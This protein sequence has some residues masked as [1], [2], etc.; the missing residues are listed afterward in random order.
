M[1]LSEIKES[2]FPKGYAP[3]NQNELDQFSDEWLMANRVDFSWDNTKNILVLKGSHDDFFCFHEYAFKDS[4]S[5]DWPREPWIA[6]RVEPRINEVG[7]QSIL[8]DYFLNKKK[9]SIDDLD[10][11]VDF[12]M[13]DDII[14]SLKN[15]D[16][17]TLSNLINQMLEEHSQAD[18]EDG[19]LKIPIDKLI[20]SVNIYLDDI[21]FHFY[22]ESEDAPNFV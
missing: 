7:A 2:W 19:I 6:Y 8:E 22:E 1:N 14:P 16:H 13:D 11:L 20:G 15:G 9:F 10:Y 5:Y 21:D 12:D 4:I 17:R 3:S 18:Y